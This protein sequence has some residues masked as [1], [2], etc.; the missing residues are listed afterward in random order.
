MIRV[1]IVDYKVGNL[2]SVEQACKTVGLES[3]ITDRPDDILAADALILPGV[4][5]FGEAMKNLYE[6][7]LIDPLKKFSDS[8]KPFMGICLG[9]Q[10]LFS[11][12]E[13]FGNCEGL[14]LIKGEVLKFPARNINGKKIKIP[15]I[16]WNQIFNPSKSGNAWDSTPLG[17]IKK[18]EFM[19]FVHSF[20]VAASGSENILSTTEYEG[21]KYCSAVIKKNIFAT[22]FHPEKSAENGLKIYRYWAEKIKSI[23]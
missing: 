9:M 1:A 10:L 17:N 20:Y 14:N 7:N 12:S 11:K 19:Y 21:I 16:G 23:R 22:Q 6:L 15:Q 3:V 18:G 2:F 5:A 13:E 4:G 8:G